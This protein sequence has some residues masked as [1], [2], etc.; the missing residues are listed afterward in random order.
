MVHLMNKQL[1]VLK[2]LNL[3]LQISSIQSIMER[4]QFCISYVPS[5][6]QS[7]TPVT[8][9]ARSTGNAPNAT[10]ISN[11]V[12]VN[13]TP[14]LSITLQPVEATGIEDSFSIFNINATTTDPDLNSQIAYQWRIDGVPLTDSASVIGSSTNQLQIK[15]PEGTY[16]IDC[17]VTHPTADGSPLAS[18]GVTF[19]SESIKEFVN[20]ET[21]D[22]FNDTEP[23]STLQQNLNDGPLNV[24]E[25]LK[26]GLSPTK[27]SRTPST[28]H[29]L[30][31]PEADVDV[32]IE[33]AAASGDSFGSI[34]P[35]QGGW[36]CFRMTLK[37]NVEYVLN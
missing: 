2:L 15:Q 3:Q 21:W 24:R 31:A 6:Y 5:A 23:F 17:V 34:Q 26:F 22:N 13:V 8:G 35:G 1:V 10:L 12:T 33:M 36:G 9:T 19:I 32:L 7:S 4:L 29:F 27:G 11:V 30:Y 16:T 25:L 14:V 37:K 20:L 18:D 28:V